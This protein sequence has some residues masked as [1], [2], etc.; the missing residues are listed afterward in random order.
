M[1]TTPLLH[2]RD[3]TRQFGSRTAVDR[4]TFD[5]HEGRVAAL[6]GPS[7]CG[8]STL[9]RIIAGLEPIDEGS[10][11]IGGVTVSAPA[12]V[13]APEKR[14]VG[15]VFQDNALFPHLDVQ[16]NVAFGIAHVEPGL[17]RRKVADLLE[18]FHVGHLARSWPHQLSGGEQQRVA[19]A[20]ALARDPA[21]LLLDEPFSGLD[22]T[23]RDTV[24]QSLMADLRAAGATVLVVTHDRAEAMIV[25]DDLVLMDRGRILQ[26]G[27]PAECYR[28][29]V[30]SAAA[31][32]LSDV[33]T[34]PTVVSSG[35]ADTP[36]GP[37]PAQEVADGPAGLIIR[38]EALQVSANGAAAAVIAAR[39]AGRAYLVTLA[40]GEATITVVMDSDP[41]AAGQSV[42]V[43]LDQALAVVRPAAGSDA[44]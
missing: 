23:L 42:H 11:S 28:K 4:A 21:L 35:I 43:E 27:S 19:I 2:V 44:H 20:R 37:V 7:G 30:S 26:V 10:V 9:L 13:L 8:K 25:A 38:P 29:P 5:L 22:G 24:R 3:A 33:L 39:F 41:P 12:D 36:F 32:L 1:T 31:R 18:R 34:L 40:I 14:G 15:L 17:R 16:S 6:L